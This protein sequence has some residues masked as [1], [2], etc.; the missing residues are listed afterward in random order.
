MTGIVHFNDIELLRTRPKN[1]LHCDA[2][3]IHLDKHKLFVNV[4]SM[5]VDI[6]RRW[7]NIEPSHRR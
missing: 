1:M 7:P 2:R 4:I 3:A 5:L 6:L